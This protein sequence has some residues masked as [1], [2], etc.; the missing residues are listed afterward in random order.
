M[1]DPSEAMAALKFAPRIR[2]ERGALRGMSGI[3]HGSSKATPCTVPVMLRTI[4]VC[5]GAKLAE[6]Q[7]AMVITEIAQRRIRIV[8]QGEPDRLASPFLHG[9]NALPVRIE[10]D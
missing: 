3:A 5:V 10:Q 6:S 9:F 2:N 1:Y 7:L 4:R 8:P